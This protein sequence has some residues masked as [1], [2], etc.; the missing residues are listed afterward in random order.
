MITYRCVVNVDPSR[1]AYIIILCALHDVAW[2]LH[3]LSCYMPLS[4]LATATNDALKMHV[5]GCKQAAKM[6]AYLLTR[7]PSATHGAHTVQYTRERCLSM[8]KLEA[9]EREAL[10]A[11][12][13]RFAVCVC[14]TL[15]LIK[16]LYCT[17]LCTRV[18]MALTVYVGMY[19][20]PA[21]YTILCL[22]NWI[23]CHVNASH[24]GLL[25]YN[26]KR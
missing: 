8:M 10:I 15:L 22:W 21:I 24:N 19:S 1:E 26:T 23:L 9:R 20:W 16:Y 5:V 7:L 2:I 3:S 17:K 14:L 18:R 6:C 13:T 25:V 4:E 12:N 11:L